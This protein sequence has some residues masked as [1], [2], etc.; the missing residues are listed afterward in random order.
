MASAI[1]KAPGCVST[2]IFDRTENKVAMTQ[3]AGVLR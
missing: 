2:E 1:R 3:Y